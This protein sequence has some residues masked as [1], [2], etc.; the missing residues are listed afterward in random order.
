M[1]ILIVQLRAAKLVVI[2]IHQ[3]ISSQS[4]PLHNEMAYSLSWPIIWFFCVK[5]AQEERHR[6]P[7]V[8]KS[9]NASTQRLKAIH[10]KEDHVCPYGEG[11][12]LQW[13]NVFQTSNKSEV[14]TY[15]RNAGIEFEW[16]AQIISEPVCQAV[17][18]HPKTS[19]TVWFNQAHL[20]HVSSLHPKV[21]ESLLSMIK[22]SDLPQRLLR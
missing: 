16:R 15:C 11:L 19:E 5:V 13:E 12:D 2:S 10:S 3:R 7:T 20:F 17:A 22:E 18:T 9:L 6:L 8:G 21:R 14:E 1:N 4:I